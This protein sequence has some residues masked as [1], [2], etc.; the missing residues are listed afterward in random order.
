MGSTFVEGTGAFVRFDAL[1][2]AEEERRAKAK[3]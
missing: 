1:V 3:H 2:K